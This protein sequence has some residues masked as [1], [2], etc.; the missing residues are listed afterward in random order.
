MRPYDLTASSPYVPATGTPEANGPSDLVGRQMNRPSTFHLD[1]LSHSAAPKIAQPRTLS[2]PFYPTSSPEPLPSFLLST[3]HQHQHHSSWFTIQALGHSSILFTI[4]F[5]IVQQGIMASRRDNRAFN[6]MSS[7]PDGA[8][9]DSFQGTPETRLTMFS[10][11]ESTS[12]MTAY[13]NSLAGPSAGPSGTASRGQNT[14]YNDRVVSHFDKDPFVD[15]HHGSGLSP[16][17]NAFNPAGNRAKGKIVVDLLPEGS[18]TVATA[19]SEDMGV[20]RDLEICATPPASLTEIGNFIADCTKKGCKLFGDRSLETTGGRVYIRFEDLRDAIWAFPALRQS[21]FSWIVVYATAKTDKL[22]DGAARTNHLGQVMISA[23]MPTRSIADPAQVVEVTQRA[24]N[25]YGK[26][27][28]MVDQTNYPDGS[29]RATAQ[30]CKINDAMAAI[31]HFSSVTVDGVKITVSGFKDAQP[32]VA[33]DNLANSMQSMTLPTLPPLPPR[34]QQGNMYQQPAFGMQHYMPGPPFV[35]NMFPMD[36]VGQGSQFGPGIFPFPGPVY[37]SFGPP[38]PA[39]TARNS[40]M[41]SRETS[42]GYGGPNGYGSLNGFGRYDARR[43]HMS[44]F[45]RGPSRGLNNNVVDLNELIGGRDVRTT[46]MLRNIPNKVDQPLLKRIVDASSYGK[47]D[48]MYL[49]IDFANDCNVGYAFINFVK[50]EY[51]INFVEERANKRWNCFK[52]DKVAEVSYATIQG[53]DCLVQ[54]FRNS[55]VMLEAEHY[56]PK[57]FYTVHCEDK[58]MIGKEEPFPGPDNQSKM[59]RSVENAEHVGLF[60]PSAGQHFR[61]EQRRRHSQFDRGTR[62]AA[63][64]EMNYESSVPLYG[65]GMRR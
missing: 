62:L 37:Q 48:F 17:A 49:R 12:K 7:P 59:K 45:G 53:K 65:R 27:F 36:R 56:R 39:M 5:T 19:L 54:K 4:S 51:I 31:H 22:L 11:S 20:C 34:Y 57:L 10:P 50:A 55:S 60:T 15:S 46:I 9:M 16:T 24:L 14:I 42:F 44:R 63:L 3:Q 43:N 61:D 38:S 29:F 28:A 64:E 18:P 2:I 13:S 40:L 52:S 32:L 23:S 25:A 1:F 35:G 58:S 21:K 26:L 33:G 6:N 8:L 47:Y 30:F 41:H